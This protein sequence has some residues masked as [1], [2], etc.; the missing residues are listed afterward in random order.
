M[1]IKSHGY[2]SY[3]Q[4]ARCGHFL[5]HILDAPVHSEDADLLHLGAN[6]SLKMPSLSQP[7][8][9]GFAEQRIITDEVIERQNFFTR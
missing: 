7:S 4:T 3:L 9:R 5:V 8:F 2:F 6:L 1:S